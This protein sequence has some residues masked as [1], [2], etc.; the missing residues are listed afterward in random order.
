ML[1]LVSIILPAYN[2]ESYLEECLESVCN[3]TYQNIEII[4]VI[5]GATDSTYDIAK[6]YAAK[7][8]RIIIVYQENAGSGPARNNGLLHAN[9][10]YVMFV[11]PDDWVDLS[12]VE[13][14]MAIMEKYKVDFITS[15]P[16]NVIFNDN[17]DE[18]GREKKECR[19]KMLVSE[20]QVHASYYELY[21]NHLLGSPTKKLYCMDIIKENNIQFPD[22]R[23]S[24]DIVF[25]YR[26]YQYIKSLYVSDG[27]FYFYRINKKSNVL[28]LPSNYYQTVILIHNEILEMYNKWGMKPSDKELVGYCN[29]FLE[30]IIRCFEAKIVKKEAIDEILSNKDI[31]NIIEKSNPVRVHKKFIRCLILNK[32]RRMLK[33]LIMFKRFF[34]K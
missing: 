12:I 3:Q 7:D 22:L 6:R 18:I 8:D 15:L 1:D 11:D 33:I 17:G 32:N 34:S 30:R 13:V 29:I 27:N 16:V 10:K 9:G 4:I 21:S 31:I 2:V 24:Q 28:K 25:N 14:F 23:R 5:D 20:E 26:Y 19:E